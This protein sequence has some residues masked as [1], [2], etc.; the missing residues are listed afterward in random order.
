MDGSA[1][2][3]LG[4]AAAA[5]CVSA[6]VGNQWPHGADS[7]AYS[8]ARARPLQLGPQ[9]RSRREAGGETGVTLFAA[10]ERRLIMTVP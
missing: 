1:A 6:S 7:R 10:S 5:R 8:R 4:R 3:S 2:P 9:R